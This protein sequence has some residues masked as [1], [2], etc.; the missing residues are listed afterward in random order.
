MKIFLVTAGSAGDI[1]PFLAIGQALQARGHQAELVTNPAFESLARSLGL[2]FTGVGTEQQYQETLAHPK[3]WHPVDGLG[4]MWRSL[5]QHQLI[6]VYERLRA[7]AADGP[8]VVLASP[9]CFGARAAQQQLG[10]PLVT[11]YT[12]AT[13]LRSC[14]DPMTMAHWHVP[15]WMPQIARRAAWRALDR[16]KLEP[17]ARPALSKLFAHAGMGWPQ[18]SMFGHWMHSPLAGVTLFPSWF[19]RAA[20]DWPAQ[21]EQAGFVFFDGDPNSGLDAP[22]SAFLQ[23]GAPPVVFMPGTAARD[24]GVF[25]RAALQACRQLGVRAVLLGHGAQE[26]AASAN[27][28]AQ[29]GVLAA[30]YAA[31]GSLLPQCSALVHHGGIGSLAQAL[32]AGLPQLLV[33]K[34]FDQFDNALRLRTLGLGMALPRSDAR[35]DG[36]A[37]ALTSLLQDSA[38]RER[39]RNYAQ[40]TPSREPLDRICALLE[41]VA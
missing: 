32:R 19:A 23:A 6:P 38:M 27:A 35:L 11:A 33:P 29:A 28:T 18:T 40:P 10:I 37:P 34:G 4:V 24:T 2:D 14:A 20:S 21:V 22:L 17:M 41:R 26:I 12:A 36:L 3:L 15:R 5:I 1:H 31:F 7:A 13:M 8:C 9:P 30:P 39:C 25:F 16:H